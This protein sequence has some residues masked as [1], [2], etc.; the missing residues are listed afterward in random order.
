MTVVE[1]ADNKL[2]VFE[3]GVFK[4]M[5]Q[6]MVSVQPTIGYVSLYQSIYYLARSSLSSSFNISLTFLIEFR[7]AFCLRLR[8]GLA[9]SRQ[10]SSPSGRYRREVR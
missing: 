4:E 10:S 7:S 2:D 3:E 5:L 6:Q 8:H 1:L 9:Y